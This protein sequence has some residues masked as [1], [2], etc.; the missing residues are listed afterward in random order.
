[1]SILSSIEDRPSAGFVTVPTEIAE[2][3]TSAINLS[4][5][6]TFLQK[7]GLYIGVGIAL[8]IAYFLFKKNKNG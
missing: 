8:I 6:K 1:M 4:R 5:D 3:K 7:Y 2:N